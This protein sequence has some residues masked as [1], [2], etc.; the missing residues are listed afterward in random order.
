MRSSFEFERELNTKEKIIENLS[1][2][3]SSE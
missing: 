3:A 2:K 1:E